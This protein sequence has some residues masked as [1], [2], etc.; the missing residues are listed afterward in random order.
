MFAW[1]DRLQILHS[2]VEKIVKV[3]DPNDIAY[4]IIFNGTEDLEFLEDL[5][6]ENTISPLLVKC[7]EWKHCKICRLL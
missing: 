4:F 1:L 6:G 3:D 2:W 7:Q 5:Y